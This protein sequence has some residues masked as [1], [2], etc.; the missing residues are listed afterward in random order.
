MEL[1]SK[2]SKR[3]VNAKIPKT[4]AAK[5]IPAS[6]QEC[7]Q[8]EKVLPMTFGNTGY[9]VTA[10]HWAKPSAYLDSRTKTDEISRHTAEK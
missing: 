8:S 7:F 10:Y 9:I 5:R 6:N 2:I 4:K 1:R 3:P